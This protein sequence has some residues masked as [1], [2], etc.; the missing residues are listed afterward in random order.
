MDE[1]V[2]DVARDK[3]YLQVTDEF[4]FLSIQDCGCCGDVD[5]ING[6]V[7]SLEEFDNF[8]ENLRTRIRP[9]F[10]EAMGLKNT[11]LTEGNDG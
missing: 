4:W 9:K 5:I 6:K 8:V 3:L 1:V 11:R 7:G 10:A 2:E